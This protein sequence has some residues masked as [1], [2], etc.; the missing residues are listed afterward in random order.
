MTS[1][2]ESLIFLLK[3]LPLDFLGG[4]VVGNL[5]AN[6]GNVALIPGPGTKIQHAAGQLGPRTPTT[7]ISMT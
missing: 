1:P 5:P 3:V 4:P 6:T 2:N 7:E